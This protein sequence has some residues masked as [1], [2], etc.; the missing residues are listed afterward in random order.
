MDPV[1]LREELLSVNGIG[2]E[3]ADSI[4]LYALNVKIFVVDAYTKRIFTR[5]GL[6]TGDPR[7]QE[8]QRLFQ[9][10]FKGSA[11]EYNEYHALIVVHGKDFCRKKPSCGECCLRSLCGK[12]I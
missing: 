9:R 12:Y 7:Y 5:L 11:R 10:H 4:L 2:P 1:E 3:T 6:L 8:I